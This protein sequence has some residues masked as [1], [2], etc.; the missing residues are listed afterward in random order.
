MLLELPHQSMAD[1][2]YEGNELAIL[3]LTY[4]TGSGT[5]ASHLSP[6]MKGEVMETGAGIGSNTIKM[7]SLGAGQWLCLETD[8]RLLLEL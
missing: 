3:W 6:S 1:Y 4:I 5:G 2:R 8:E 7:R